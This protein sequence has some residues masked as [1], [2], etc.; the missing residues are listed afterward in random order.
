MHYLNK[1]LIFLSLYLF[2]ASATFAYNSANDIVITRKAPTKKALLDRKFIFMQ[3]AASTRPTLNVQ[4]STLDL[5]DY[6]IKLVPVKVPSIQSNK[7]NT[8]E[9]SASSVQP[10][11]DNWDAYAEEVDV[12][13]EENLG[14]EAKL[15]NTH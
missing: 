7:K 13:L 8:V 15:L 6:S 11:A 4:R 12:E 10:V 3:E 5:H 14:V 9:R 2:T 1:A